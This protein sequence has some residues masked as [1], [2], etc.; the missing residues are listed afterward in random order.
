VERVVPDEGKGEPPRRRYGDP[1]RE[2]GTGGGKE[3]GP[4]EAAVSV[5]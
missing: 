1:A 4:G 5:T 2:G 3:R